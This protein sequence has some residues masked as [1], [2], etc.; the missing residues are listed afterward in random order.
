MSSTGS[1]AWE[2]RDMRVLVEVNNADLRI[3]AVNDALDLAELARPSG[4]R[5]ILCGPLTPEF[6][7]EAGRR[8]IATSQSRSRTF[9][10]RGL[11]LYAIHVLTWIARLA[12]WRPDVVHINYP[13]YGPSLACAAWL[14]GIPVVARAGGAFFPGNLSNR[15]VSAYVANCLAHAQSLLDSP[16][17]DRVVVAGDL[18]RPDRVRSTLTP[19]RA[20]PARTAGVARLVFLGQLV[21]RKGLHV[22]VEALARMESPCELLLAGGDWSA[23]GYPERVKA[24]AAAAGVSSR[25]HF[26]NHRQDVGALLNDADVFVLPSFSEA[27]PRSII[28][29]MSVGIPIVASDVGGI[30]SLVVHDVTGLLVPAGDP[31]RLAAALDSLIR[32]KDLRDRLGAAARSHAEREC[33]ADRTAV[34]YVQLYRRLRS[35]RPADRSLQ[36]APGA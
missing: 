36:H 31:G 9:S 20:I 15:W 7:A 21:E 6:C 1:V 32:S 35:G 8:G 34:E 24:I 11:P 29:A 14:C 27:R 33:R 22:L 30:P 28:E 23:P 13:G 19:E 5:F 4:T 26:E 17:R 10:R 12:W 18:F 16:L 25:I 2:V 3:G